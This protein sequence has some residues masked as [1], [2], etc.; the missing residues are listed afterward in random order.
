[1]HACDADDECR[2]TCRAC[3]L[4]KR[5]QCLSHCTAMPA[6]MLTSAVQQM[7]YCLFCLGSNSPCLVQLLSDWLLCCLQ[8]CCGTFNK[9]LHAS[10]SPPRWHSQDWLCMQDWLTNINI[11]FYESKINLNWK[12][13]LKSIMEVA[14]CCHALGELKPVRLCWDWAA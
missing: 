4:S 10:H 8:S 11:K 12:P 2:Q 7:H 3:Y 5:S 6:D 9:A 14:P 13:I 1:M